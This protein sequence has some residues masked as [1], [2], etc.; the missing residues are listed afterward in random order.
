MTEPIMKRVKG[1]GV[2]IQ[3]AEWEG[4]GKTVLCVHGLTANCRCWDVLAEAITPVNR[5]IAMDLRGRG[6]SGKPA[7]GYS[8]EHHCRDILAVLDDLEL[9][10]AVIMGHSLGAFISLIFGALHPERVDRIIL[11]DGGGKL[12]ETQREKV[13]AGIKPLLDRLGKVFPSFEDY[14]ALMKGAPF[15]NPWTSALDT[16]YEYEIEAVKGGI[17]SRIKPEHIQEEAL[18]LAK[19]DV[20]QFYKKI[21]C[22]VL[23]LRATEGLLA[24]DDILLPE[25]VV[26]RMVR[27]IPDARRVDLE[28]ANHY[29]VVFQPNTTRDQAIMAFL[30]ETAKPHGARTY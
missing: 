27:E 2:E 29:F 15:L 20:S 6:L 26:E 24:P 30:K 16:Y 3:L 18:N 22:P 21:V 8:I 17:C 11:V 23:I 12:S 5:M 4:E 28:G 9:E 1:D 14:L 10:R 25:E 7:T 13:F 19:V